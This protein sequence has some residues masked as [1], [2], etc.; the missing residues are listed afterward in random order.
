MNLTPEQITAMI[1]ALGY[2]ICV[3]IALYAIS[4]RLLSR[5]FLNTDQFAQLSK[6][7]TEAMNRNSA[8]MQANTRAIEHMTGNLCRFPPH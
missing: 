1:Q 6:E 3:S 5:H 4:W 7:S 8:A 2:P